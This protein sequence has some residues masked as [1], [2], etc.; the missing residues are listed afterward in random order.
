MKCTICFTLILLV[1]LTVSSQINKNL[2]ITKAKIDTT[3]LI[4]KMPLKAVLNPQKPDTTITIKL[5]NAKPDY[6][7][8]IHFDNPENASG[9]TNNFSSAASPVDSQQ[10]IVSQRITEDGRFET[11]YADGSKKTSYKGSSEPISSKGIGMKS[12]AVSV[13]PFIP[14]T[15]PNDADIT[16]YLQNVSDQ[17]LRILYELL[18]RDNA[19]IVNFKKGDANHNIYEIIY[20]RIE[21]INYCNIQK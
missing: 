10:K 15:P 11:T 17:L 6:L 4:M 2:I 13:L 1:S 7:L 14:P 19:S 3:S 5:T 20:R 9:L 18:N 12:S 16:K 21:F 8:Q